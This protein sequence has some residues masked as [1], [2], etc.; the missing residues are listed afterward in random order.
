MDFSSELDV[1]VGG[2]VEKIRVDCLFLF[3]DAI[4]PGDELKCRII[5]YS[6]FVLRRDVFI[7]WI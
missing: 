2:E 4:L 5:E 6:K 7:R 3:I 1:C